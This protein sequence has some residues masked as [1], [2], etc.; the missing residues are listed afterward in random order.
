MF[1]FR[2]RETTDIHFGNG[3]RIAAESASAAAATDRC[4][5]ALVIAGIARTARVCARRIAG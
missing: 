2:L 1:S 4:G 5:A 3:R